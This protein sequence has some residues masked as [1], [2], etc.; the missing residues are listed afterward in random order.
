M[1]DE[2]AQVRAALQRLKSRGG[3]TVQAHG[4][5][6]NH[7]AELEASDVVGCFYC[8]ET[9]APSR[10]NAWIDDGTTALC[11]LCGIDSVVGD[12]SGYPAGDPQFL[13]QMNGVWF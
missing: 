2:M 3:P 11:P 9:Y 8:C 13:K 12:A 5:S 6:A 7:R 1:S 10:V 4:H